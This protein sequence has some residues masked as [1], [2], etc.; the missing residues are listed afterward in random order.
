MISS[1]GTSAMGPRRSTP[2]VTTTWSIRPLVAYADSMAAATSSIRETSVP[3][4]DRLNRWTVAPKPWARSAT[5]APM[6]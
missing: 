5:S 6:P 2:A 3:V 1:S 4:A